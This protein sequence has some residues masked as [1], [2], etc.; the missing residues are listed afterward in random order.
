MAEIDETIARNGSGVATAEPEVEPK[1][2]DAG[3]SAAAMPASTDTTEATDVTPGFLSELSGAMRS[4]LGRERERVAATVRD[5]AATHA[6]SARAQSTAEAEAFRQVADE[7]VAAIEAWADGEIERIRSEAARTAADRQA[8]LAAHLAQHEAVL[9]GELR[10]IDAAVTEYEATLGAYLDDLD[11]TDDPAEIAQR[12]RAMPRPPDL[13]TV[14]SLARAD[15]L[16]RLAEQSMHRDSIQDVDG[17]VSLDRGADPVPDHTAAHMEGIGP[18]R[19]LVAV[20]DAVATA[21]PGPPALPDGMSVEEPAFGHPNAAVRL[22][23]SVAPWTAPNHI[24]DEDGD[25]Q[26]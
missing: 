1:V 12:A 17:A 8:D 13:D 23:R 4:V 19:E 22:L 6:A 16:T 25:R 5:D 26:D 18:E 15:A 20:M 11:A 10:G 7:D 2:D 9:E 24:Q 3:A 21:E 14:R